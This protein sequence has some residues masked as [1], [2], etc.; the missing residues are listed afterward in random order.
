MLK[1]LWQIERAKSAKIYERKETQENTNSPVQ[2][3]W[4]LIAK[5]LFGQK[6]SDLTFTAVTPEVT[7]GTSHST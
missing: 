2:I 7:Y 4:P 6:K 5:F 3:S 1:I